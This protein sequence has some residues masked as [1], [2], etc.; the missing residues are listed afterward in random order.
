MP[1]VATNLGPVRD[2]NEIN[3]YDTLAGPLWILDRAKVPDLALSSYNFYYM[4][5][6]NIRVALWENRTVSGDAHNS[7]GVGT[8]TTPPSSQ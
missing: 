5:K 8:M 4:F 1:Q 7:M 6:Y 3:T 2:L